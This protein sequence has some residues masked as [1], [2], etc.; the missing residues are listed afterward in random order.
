VLKYSP[1]IVLGAFP[2]GVIAFVNSSFLA[3][4]RFD[5]AGNL[6]AADGDDNRL[7]SPPFSSSMRILIYPSYS[8]LPQLFIPQEETLKSVGGAASYVYGQSNLSSETPEQVSVTSLYYPTSLTLAHG[9]VVVCSSAENRVL[10][11][12]P[13]PPAVNGIAAIRVL[14]QPDFMSHN[15]GSALDEMFLPYGVVYDDATNTLWVTDTYNNRI[16][17]F[18]NSIVP[19]QEL[20]PLD[21][22]ITFQGQQ[23]TVFFY[24]KGLL[25]RG[26]T[27]LKSSLTPLTKI[28]PVSGS[29]Y[30]GQKQLLIQPQVIEELD[31]NETVTSTTALPWLNYTASTTAHAWDNQYF[32]FSVVFHGGAQVFPC[33]GDLLTP[34]S[35]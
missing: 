17:R 9:M 21:V 13:G 25:R 6:Y 29:I 15:R 18:S 16:L 34:P 28:D 35:L 20:A 8:F 27:L 23:P 32:V 4:V 5:G 31:S 12:P 3:D 22:V 30:P 10:V 19:V 24:P 7:V 1:P 26:Y 33:D 2:D 14:G 11:F